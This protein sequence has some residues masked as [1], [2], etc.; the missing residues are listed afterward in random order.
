MERRTVMKSAAMGAVMVATMGTMIVATKGQTTAAQPKTRTNQAGDNSMFDAQTLA[1]RYVA[2]W[3]ERNEGSRRAAIA[4]LW[5]PDGQHYVQGQEARGHAAL[6]KRI[7]GSHERN[8][9]D[10]GNRFRAA[11]DARRLHDVV[12]FHWEMLPADSETVLVR[13]LEF[14]IIRDDGHIL[15]DYQFFPA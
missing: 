15:V 5:V 10:N 7:R 13:G 11:R 14:L 3:N 12:T 1:D 4:A 9:R 2:V 6:E 8:V